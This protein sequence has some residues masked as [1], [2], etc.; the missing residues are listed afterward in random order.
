MWSQAR[1]HAH[2]HMQSMASALF[3]PSRSL[4]SKSKA[5][6]VDA[7]ASIVSLCKRRGFVFPTADLYGGSGIGYD[8]GPL[9]AQLVHNLSSRWWRDFVTA[10]RDVLPLDSC[11]L[12][13]AALW[14]AS[15]HLEHFVDP[16][17]ECASCHARFRADHI[18][19]DVPGGLH[20]LAEALQA[21]GRRCPACGASGQDGL[22]G[23]FHTAE[24]VLLP[25]RTRRMCRPADPRQFNMLFNTSVGPVAGDASQA[26]LR[27]E[28]AQAVYA[29]W[30]NIVQCTRGK[31]PMGIATLGRSYRN[32]I[33]TGNFIFRTREFTQAEI[34]YFCHPQQSDQVHEEW[35]TAAWQ[36][37]L[38]LGLPPHK[39]RK[40]QHSR[41]QLAHYALATTDIEYLYPF[42]WGE[43]WCV[44]PRA[45]P[46]IGPARVQYLSFAVPQGHFKPR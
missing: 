4:A 35:V 22:T 44:S 34:Q 33:S 10:R 7:L 30:R 9:G 31:L 11:T 27:P 20:G 32:E 26:Y 24:R 40:R 1:A 21:S 12:A 3:Q 6:P 25:G 16:L 5:A 37:L 14:Q 28:T 29:Q 23:A 15:G 45:V 43:L 42:G 41:D 2:E 18:V 17:T 8:Y 19:G 39:L 13:P 38:Q 46:R 36:W